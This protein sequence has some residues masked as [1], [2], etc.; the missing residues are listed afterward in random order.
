MSL[1]VALLGVL[2]MAACA[3]MGRPEGGPRDTEPP[4]YVRSNP[5]D[6]A[7]GVRTD[8][9]MV[10]FDENIQLDDPAGKIIV[11]P[12][13]KNQPRVQAVGRRIY[14]N[15]QD[16][17]LPDATYTI[18]F[19]ESIK[20]L[21]EG[22]P[23]TQFALAFATGQTL[24]TLAIS[25]MVLQAENLEPAQSMLVGVHPADAADTAIYTQPFARV[26]KTNQY[27]QF[28]IRNLAPGQYR[29]YALND[30]NRDGHWDRSED[31][32]FLPHTI[33][34][35]AQQVTVADTLVTQA[36]LDSI[37]MRQATRLLPDNLLLTWFNTGYKPQY[38]T[39]Y[40]RPLRHQIRLLMATTSDTLP[41]LRIVSTDPTLNGTDLLHLSRLEAS[42]TLD[43]LTYHLTDPTIIAMDSMALAVTHLR[44]DTLDQLTWTTD[45]LQFNLRRPKHTKKSGTDTSGSDLKADTVATPLK[46][47]AATS[48]TIDVYSRL[49][50]KLDQPLAT[51]DTTAVHLHT[52]PPQDTVWIPAEPPRFA[53]PD[54]YHPLTLT[55]TYTWTPGN[56]YRL[57]ID[58]AAISGYTGQVNEPFKYEFSVR[59]LKEYASLTLQLPGTDTITPIV[60][61]LNNQDKPIYAAAPRTGTTTVRFTNLTPGQYY[62]RLFDDRNHNGHYD[63]GSLTDTIPPEDVYYYPKRLNLKQNWDIEQTW[64]IWA[65][66]VD[67]QK[68]EAIKKNK[69]KR[70]P[71]DPNATTVD[72]EDDTDQYYDENGNP[73]VDPN[74]PFGKRQSRTSSRKSSPTTPRVPTSAPG[75]RTS[76]N[77]L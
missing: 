34:P 49:T 38:I 58:T 28:T 3:S 10:E 41:T 48:G 14:V 76:Q 36:G 62:I 25:G 20:D 24:D 50:L 17:L 40:E 26:T 37:V 55:S 66:P 77:R 32:A 71:G 69:P 53:Q 43:T 16:T 21:N 68:P 7:L 59:S 72:D 18:D 35:T 56:K 1:L 42:P 9:I 61:L 60:Q 64:D 29:I 15:L 4:A 6:G 8:R 5:A 54:Q 65:T 67:K 51:F 63:T 33:T 19:T 27:G 45:T 2:L 11:S 23:L 22:N 52:L 75:L 73:A 30:V 70:N 39:T 57:E 47:Q 13:Q 46:L 31:I 44:T 74:D 12:T